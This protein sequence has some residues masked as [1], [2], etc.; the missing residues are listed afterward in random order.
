M[1]EA[2][3]RGLLGQ[4]V[5]LMGQWLRAAARGPM[6][7]IA[8]AGLSPGTRKRQLLRRR[9]Q[10]ASRPSSTRAMRVIPIACK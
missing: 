1:L 3:L 2:S 10:A 5:V 8:S 9:K 6:E 4:T 7:N